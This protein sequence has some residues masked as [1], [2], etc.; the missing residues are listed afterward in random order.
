MPFNLQRM[1]FNELLERCKA[2]ASGVGKHIVTSSTKTRRHIS[3]F[4][5]VCKIDMR[6]AEV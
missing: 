5:P 2:P 3:S 6:G 1:S 4:P